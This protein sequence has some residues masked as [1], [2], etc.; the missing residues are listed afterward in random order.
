MWKCLKRSRGP[1]LGTSLDGFSLRDVSQA[2][3]QPMPSPT[4]GERRSSVRACDGLTPPPHV[5]L[6][7]AIKLWLWPGTS[8]A[9]EMDRIL[10]RREMTVDEALIELKRRRASRQRRANAILF[11]VLV[12]VGGLTLALLGVH[13]AAI[14]RG[15]AQLDRRVAIH[16]IISWGR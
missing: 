13:L 5:A 4:R 6:P 9:R 14:A 1:S 3:G 10:R 16:E 7:S 12:A 15:S 2:S 8:L 11:V